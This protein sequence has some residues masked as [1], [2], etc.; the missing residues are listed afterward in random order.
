V[1]YLFS[2]E[3]KNVQ[4][5]TIALKHSLALQMKGCLIAAASFFTFYTMLLRKP[6]S[7]KSKKEES[8]KQDM[9]LVLY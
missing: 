2:F 1:F 4:S 3:E 7:K 9:G 6:I 5:P 8:G